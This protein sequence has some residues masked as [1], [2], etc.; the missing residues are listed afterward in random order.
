MSL[1]VDLLN[2]QF[3]GGLIEACYVG[4]LICVTYAKV[5]LMSDWR[6]LHIFALYPCT[7]I[8]Y[9]L[10]YMSTMKD[11]KLAEWKLYEIR[12]ANMIYNTIWAL[13]TLYFSDQPYFIIATLHL[14]LFFPFFLGFHLYKWGRYITYSVKK[15]WELF[16]SDNTCKDHGH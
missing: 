6:N 4:I 9:L 7:S 16:K 2:L 1:L 3:L 15:D 5:Y 8:G 14:A 11:L 10:I 13:I 12:T